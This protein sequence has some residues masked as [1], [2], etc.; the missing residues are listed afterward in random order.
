MRPCAAGTGH[1]AGVGRSGIRRRKPKHR[2]PPPRSWE[3]YD[4][5]P[6]MLWHEP[7]DAFDPSPLSPAGRALIGWR[8]VQSLSRGGRQRRPWLRIATKTVLVGMLLVLLAGYVVSALG[9]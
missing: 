7:G 5:P 4:A 6:G 1:H 9:G 2:L 3:G 8:F